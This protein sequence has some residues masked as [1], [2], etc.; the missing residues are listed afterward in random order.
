MKSLFAICLM[1]L[2]P[3]KI[4]A[5]D[6]P[7][8]LGVMAVGLVVSDIAT[9]EKFYTEVLGMVPAGEFSLDKT[10]SEEAG[11]AGGKPFS[12][13]MFKLQNRKSAT[14]LKLAYFD[15]TAPRP[16]A[17]GVD[18]HAGVNYLTL[19]YD[20]IHEVM[21]RVDKAGIATLGWVK[22]EGYQLAFIR[23]PD[24]MFIEI[25]GPPD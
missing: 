1:F 23:D 15:E 12:V 10:W 8:E 6:S 22:R 25:V 3:I 20:N 4:I 16:Q 13:K 14:I 2:L 9:S 19:H 18:S 7:A 21:K 17:T 11:A 24:G 5:Q